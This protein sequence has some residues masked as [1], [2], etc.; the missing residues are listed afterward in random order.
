MIVKVL[1]ND[2]DYRAS[3]ISVWAGDERTRR[4][5]SG[6]ILMLETDHEEEERTIAAVHAWSRAQG[7]IALS[8][9]EAEYYALITTCQE[10]R[11][12][13]SLLQEVLGRRIPVILRTDSDAARLAVEKRGST[14]QAHGVATLVSEGASEY[15]HCAAHARDEQEEHRRSPH[16]DLEPGEDHRD[17]E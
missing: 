12:L 13:Q 5:T 8:S 1:G 10:A 17:F 11:A 15:R 6:G 2:V 4:S 9:M 16:E 7:P 3:T 14:L